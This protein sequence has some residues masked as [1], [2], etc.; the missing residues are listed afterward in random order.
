MSRF[1]THVLETMTVHAVCATVRRRTSGG[2]AAELVLAGE[3]ATELGEMGDEVLAYL[4]HCLLGGNLAVG[5]DANEKLRHVRVRYCFG[6]ANMSASTSLRLALESF[7][8]SSVLAEGDD[9]LLLYPAIRTLGCFFRCSE[10]R[11]PRVWSSFFRVK[12]EQLDMP[13]IQLL[14]LRESSPTGQHRHHQDG[15]LTY[16]GKESR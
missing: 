9:D 2:H 10:T 3:L 13:W 16:E 6:V 12:S 7:S 4:D 5:L 8:F 14:D 1:G 15:A 11:F